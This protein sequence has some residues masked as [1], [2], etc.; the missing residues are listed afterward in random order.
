VYV[1]GTVTSLTG[2]PE[3]TYWKDNVPTTLAGDALSSSAIN[4]LVQGNDIYIPGAI[5]TADGISFGY[6]KNGTMNKL[7]SSFNG[8]V[9][10][11]SDIIVSGN[12]IYVGGL[13]NINGAK[14]VAYWKNSVEIFKSTYSSQ[15]TQSNMAVDGSN[16]YL[17]ETSTG[18]TYWENGIEKKLQ[19]PPDAFVSSIFIAHHN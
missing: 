12:D 6:W 1:T 17:T 15:T 11:I 5:Q 7:T 10:G 2:K 9:A 14:H 13:D 19:G 16:V 3:A 18:A 8:I 4:I